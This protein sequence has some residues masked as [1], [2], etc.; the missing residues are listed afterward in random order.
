MTIYTECIC[1]RETPAVIKTNSHLPQDFGFQTLN[2]TWDGQIYHGYTLNL[3]YGVDP[4]T[5][6]H[7]PNVDPDR[8]SHVSPK[9]G[10]R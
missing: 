3:F 7:G 1:C 4:R 2:W 9:I 5:S 8:F 10:D 6:V